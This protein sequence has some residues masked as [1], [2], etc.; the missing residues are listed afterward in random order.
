VLPIFN[1][2]Q[3]RE[4]DA[5]TIGRKPISSIDLMEGAC[6]AFVQWFVDK[7]D[8][9]R[10]V[11]IIC[12]S[13]NNGGDGL[14][15]ARLLSEWNYP[16]TVWL[17][18]GGV[19]ES[20]DFKK[21]FARLPAKVKVNG[22]DA[23]NRPASFDCDVLIDA[24]FGSGLSRPAE[25]L[26]AE[27]INATNN[28]NATRVAVDIPSGLFADK[29][30]EGPIVKADMTISF[31]LPK[32]AFLLPENARFVGHW[33]LVDIGLDKAFIKN[34]PT[35]Y[36]LL[37]RQAVKKTVHRR[38]TFDHK[39]TYGKAL[40]VSGSYGKMGA[41]VLGARAAI[42]AGLGLLTVHVPKSGYV[43]IQ[44]SVPEAMASVDDDDK[45]ITDVAVADQYDAIGI[46]PGIGQAEKTVAGIRKVLEAG[47]PMV[48]DAD[49]LNI[50]AAHRELLRIIPAGSILTPHPKE[51]E[52][53]TGQ[54]RNDFE[55]LSMLT[56]MAHAYKSVVVLK[57]AYTSIATPDRNVYFNSTGNPGMAT[58]GSGDVLTGILTGLM[59][60]KYSAEEAAI[61]GVYVHGLAGD[62]AARE[63][64]M[65]SLIAS[66]IV[67]FLPTAFRD[68]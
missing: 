58:G 8:G 29:H 25:G 43:I 44:T 22:Y 3:I 49:A 39:G 4:L 53:L 59:A 63:R 16:I 20:D 19:K 66:D 26:Y 37:T 45:I 31:Q 9:S 34:T 60:Q 11:A 67:E 13:G 46:G 35:P 23:S 56:A 18:K 57:G 48:I 2:Q 24:I 64:T 21:N 10:R 14:G 55:R 40:L 54:W 41:C 62:L 17:V 28:S 33:Q 32:L 15:I 30:S 6:R 5:C 7:Y 51:F 47:K 36:G 38:E 12:G 42:R 27:A 50:L 68:M 52:R 1:T 65:N 61:L